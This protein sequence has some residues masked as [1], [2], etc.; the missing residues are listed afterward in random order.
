MPIYGYAANFV[1]TVVAA[2]IVYAV[3]LS[4]RKRLAA[5]T[6][7]RAEEQAARL[8]KDAERDAEARKKEALLEAKAKIPGS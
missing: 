4:N 8:T 7:G 2:G 6:V 3:W 5:D 1:I